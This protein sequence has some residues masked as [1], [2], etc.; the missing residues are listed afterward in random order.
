[1]TPFVDGYWILHWDLTEPHRQQVLTHPVVH[2]TF[3]TGGQAHITGI[4][5]DTFALEISGP[6]RALGLRFRPGGFRPF[7]TAPVS[8]LTDRVLDIEEIFGP[9]A[10]NRAGCRGQPPSTWVV[11]CGRVS[12]HLTGLRDPGPWHDSLASLPKRCCRPGRCRA[13]DVGRPAP[14]GYA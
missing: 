8:A 11:S 9:A 12:G 1:M 7:L 14:T 3:T 2:L 10:H 5:S 4:V 6:G 13:A